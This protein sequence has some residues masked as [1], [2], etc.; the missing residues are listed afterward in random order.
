[1]KKKHCKQVLLLFDLLLVLQHLH[2]FLKTEKKT[3]SLPLKKVVAIPFLVLCSPGHMTKKQED[4][5]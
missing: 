1:M 4:R 3:Q 5:Q 2:L